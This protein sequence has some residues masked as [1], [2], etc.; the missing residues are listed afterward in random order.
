[1]LIAG[2]AWLLWRQS[3]RLSRLGLGLLV[4]CGLGVLLVGFVPENGSMR[5]HA[6]GAAMHFLGG[7]LGMMAAGWRLQGRARWASVTIGVMVVASTILL[8][9]RGSQWVAQ[10]GAGAIERVAAYGIV[11]WMVG[12]GL[13]LRT[14]SRTS[15]SR[16][17]GLSAMR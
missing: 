5:L 15:G 8:G 12:T 16:T 2:G 1:M 14:I 13:Y 4:V 7:G 10:L 17:G 3:S 9:Q 11:L 6:L